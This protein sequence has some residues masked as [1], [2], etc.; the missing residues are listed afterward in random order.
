MIF[1]RHAFAPTLSLLLG[2]GVGCSVVMATN[3]DVSR[4]DNVTDCDEPADARFV[5]SCIKD[6]NDVPGVCVAEFAPD[7][8]CNVESMA[9]ENESS[10]VGQV[11]KAWAVS[12]NYTS[13][14]LDAD[15]AG[16][17]GCSPPC[18]AGLELDEESGLC[19]D[20]AAG[21]PRAV[22]ARA[23][24][25]GRDIADQFCRS[26]FCDVDFACN[27]DIC[28][29]CDP[30]KDVGEGGCGS[31]YMNG[32]PSCVYTTVSALDEQCADPDSASD[33]VTFGDCPML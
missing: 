16:K 29:P 6:A 26:Y 10:P 30:A 19:D 24:L 14:C 11:W 23:E 3:D 2:L 8:P 33:K 28:S 17:A 4:C 9:E 18:Q 12:T 15:N 27:N 21:T 32:E 1:A 22:P 13:G 20:T 25:L 7:V 5:A 31:L